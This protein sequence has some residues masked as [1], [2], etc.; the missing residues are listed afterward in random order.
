MVIQKRISLKENLSSLSFEGPPQ[1]SMVPSI[2]ESFD[3]P[4]PNIRESTSGILFNSSTNTHE[5]GG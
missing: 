1:L 3:T 5:R 2:S 4:S